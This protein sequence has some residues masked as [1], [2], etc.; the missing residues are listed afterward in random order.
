M[1]EEGTE[2]FFESLR[3]QEQFLEDIKKIE[4]EKVGHLARIFTDYLGSE[5]THKSIHVLSMGRS[6]LS[7]QSFLQGL[8]NETFKLASKHWFY[9]A[10]LRDG[11]I[12]FIDEDSLTLIVSGSGETKE[13]IRYLETAIRFGSRLVLITG[14]ED[15][16]AYRK[17][18]EE[19]G[20]AFLLESRSKESQEVQ[21]S[22]TR[23]SPLGSEF[24]LK[25]WLLL[26]SLVPQIISDLEGRTGRERS[27]YMER[28][29]VFQRNFRLLRETEW[30]GKQQLDRWIQRLTHRHG[31]FVFYGVT[32][33]GHVAEQFEMR[34]AHAN[35]NVFMLTDSNRKP[36]KH[37]DVC[38]L[39]SGS[40]NTDDII[41]AA[42]DALGAVEEGGTIR[43]LRGRPSA[44]VFGVTVNRNS[45]LKR[46]LEAAGQEENLLYLP[47]EENYL[48][49][50]TNSSSNS[51]LYPSEI[52]RYRIPVFETS[53]Y[54]VTNAIVSQV[55]HNEGIIP[56]VFF[57]GQHV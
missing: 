34:F 14:N 16:R 45:H 27:D 40:G 17:V 51:I 56:Q 8:Y 26:N 1:S 15:S 21:E 7:T 53:A 41:D 13:V 3:L 24:E 20:Y 44:E 30:I 22:F 12:K 31:L 29:E 32:R 55:G 52:D 11:V 33:S 46:I 25:V 48:R 54:V 9:P 5:I 38:I 57:R 37:G 2:V 35:K 18:T 43:F 4:A 49:D 19:G 47:V 39:I 36:F 28:L 42:L 10:T 23:L 6:A 50:F